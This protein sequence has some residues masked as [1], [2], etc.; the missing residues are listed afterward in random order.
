[1]CPSVCL[2]TLPSLNLIPRHSTV[3]VTHHRAIDQDALRKY[4]GEIA[5]A[6]AL[7]LRNVY[8]PLNEY[9]FEM[10]DDMIQAAREL[11]IACQQSS[12]S[13]GRDGQRGLLDEQDERVDAEL[14]EPLPDPD[15]DDGEFLIN[16][17]RVTGAVPVDQL[18]TPSKS[19]KTKL[20]YCG[21][22]QPT[23]RK[24]LLMLYT[25]LPAETQSRTKWFS[26]LN[27]YILLRSFGTNGQ[28]QASMVITQYISALLFSGRL[29][30]YSKMHDIIEENPQ[31]T[32]N[33]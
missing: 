17:G 18:E 13:N 1:M 2:H 6:I 12:K 7:V 4:G 19:T 28:W 10:D 27:R 32:Y 31:C 26:V 11:A 16:P 20:H 22:V 9:E 24:L 33:K 15:V 8:H 29:I 30:L 23:L 3:Y 5:R 21:I 14:D 25:Q